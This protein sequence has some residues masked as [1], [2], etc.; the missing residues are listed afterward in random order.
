M[1]FF[2]GNANTHSTEQ[3][4]LSKAA[5]LTVI[6]RSKIRSLSAE[7]ESAAERAILAARGSNERISLQ[8]IDDAL[9]SLENNTSFT[10][11]DRAG[12]VKAFKAYFDK[13]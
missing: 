11:A 3:K 12:I 2:F 10:A 5:I 4:K 9:K 13:Q 6:S 7:D 8:Q 1:G